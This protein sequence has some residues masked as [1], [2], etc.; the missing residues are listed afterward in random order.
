MKIERKNLMESKGVLRNSV[1]RI[2]S[3]AQHS[4]TKVPG[5]W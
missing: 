2:L 1:I 5:G 3:L 4:S